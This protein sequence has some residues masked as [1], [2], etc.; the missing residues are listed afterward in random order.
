MFSKEALLKATQVGNRYVVLK[1]AQVIDDQM[2]HHGV[3]DFS[4]RINEKRFDIYQK[5]LEERY[6]SQLLDMDS[7]SFDCPEY[8]WHTSPLWF[9][10]LQGKENMPSLP[11]F[12]YEN[13]LKK[14]GSHPVKFIDF[15]SLEDYIDIPSEVKE[16]F[17]A[18]KI[19]AA[20]YTDIIR[21]ALL[22]KYGGAWIDSTVFLKEPLPDYIFSHTDWCVKGLD[23]RFKYKNAIVGA[24]DWQS[25]FVAARPDSVFSHAMYE[26]L[27]D[28]A[29]DIE[30]VFEYFTAFFFAKILRE[31]IAL[32]DKS[33]RNIPVNNERCELL[34]A[35]IDGYGPLDKMTLDDFKKSGTFVYKMS[36]RSS[37][38]K[39][40]RVFSQLLN[41]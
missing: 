2:V 24:L 15:N 25:Y 19:S 8:D 34:Q 13:L 38:S 22:S 5:W 30:C 23:G 29:I 11:Q 12:N 36:R 37:F 9:C 39:Q 7:W 14:A 18:G 40:E 4:A 10:W 33:Y 17:S 26:L 1:L 6:R 35:W 27:V 31:R 32:V 21:F 28:Y 41:D 20:F 3:K 16:L